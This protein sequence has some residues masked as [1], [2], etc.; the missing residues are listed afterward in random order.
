MRKTTI[1]LIAA[2]IVLSIGAMA[3]RL[4]V[5]GVVAVV[6]DDVILASE[7]GE[8]INARI[9]QYGPE[10]INSIGMSNFTAQILQEMIDNRLLLQKADEME[11]IISRDDVDP[12]VEDN[13]EAM[14]EPYPT[15]EEFEAM[16]QQY[17]MTEKKLRKQYRKSIKE[18]IT[19]KNLVDIEIMPNI[20]VNED[21][22]RAYYEINKSEFDI[23]IM[24]GISEIV[25]PKKVSPETERKAKTRAEEVRA[26]AL[27]GIDFTTLVGQYSAGGNAA[28]GGYFN[29]STGE[30]YPQLEEAA[31]LLSPGEVSEPISLQDGF[32]VLKLLE[33]TDDS[34]KTQVILVPVELTSADIT[35]ARN[36]A[37]K[38]HNELDSGKA[39]AEVA[40]T[41]NVESE[42]SDSGGYVGQFAL[43]GLQ[44]D[45]PKI[46]S[47]LE[48]LQPGE[49]TSVIERPEGFYIVQLEEM[50]EGESRDYAGARDEVI[51]KLRMEK[52]DEEINK[53]VEELKEESYIKVVQE[54]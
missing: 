29:F 40:A 45:F 14:K 19:I 37:E 6:N 5:D 44:R 36:K 3:E 28:A 25:I 46:A 10:A 7:V 16:L 20:E 53:Y 38:A 8:E 26:K 2:F 39:F 18:Q 47:E 21:D 49:Y 4:P 50:T 13:I 23:P 34:Y 48:M 1:L 15:E 11:I 12:L 54:E 9:Y 22:A 51:N 52:L 17:G 30:T 35:V 43:W 42:I 31:A 32:W 41:Y 27:R 33:K 24:V